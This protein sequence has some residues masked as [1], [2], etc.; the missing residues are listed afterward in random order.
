MNLERTLTSPQIEA[1]YKSRDVEGII[2]IYSY[3]KIGFLLARFVA[4]LNARSGGIPSSLAQDYRQRNRHMTKWFNVLTVEHTNANSFRSS[5]C[6][7]THLVFLNGMLAFV[8]VLQN[9]M[10]REICA[11]LER[12]SS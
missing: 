11:G 4:W 1:T 12:R 5:A 6:R 7:Y 8:L 9:R 2:D 10:S 3:W